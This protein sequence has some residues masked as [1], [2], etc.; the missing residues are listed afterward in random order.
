MGSGIRPLFSSRSKQSWEFYQGPSNHSRDFFLFGLYLLF[1]GTVIP[2]FSSCR[3]LIREVI[4]FRVKLWQYCCH[5]L[6]MQK[7]IAQL[8]LAYMYIMDAVIMVETWDFSQIITL[9]HIS[10]YP[11]YHYIQYITISIVSLYSIYH[12]T[13]YI[14]VSIITIFHISLYPLPIYPL[15]HYIHSPYIHFLL[16]YIF[17]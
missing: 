8:V 12:Y 6:D 15:L 7:I 4:Q 5:S 1:C 17:I 2:M 11:I 10:L 3:H 14:T 9:S 13:Q 16:Y